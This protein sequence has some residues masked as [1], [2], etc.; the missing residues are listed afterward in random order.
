MAEKGGAA[1]GGVADGGERRGVHAGEFV[2]FFGGPTRDGIVDSTTTPL[3][4]ESEGGESE[5]DDCEEEEK[6]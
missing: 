5:R 3:E 1:G 2:G 4:N 6:L